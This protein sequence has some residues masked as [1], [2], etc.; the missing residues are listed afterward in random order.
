MLADPGNVLLLD[1]PTN[2]LDIHSID[3]LA[4]A[5][6]EFEGTVI[7]VSHDERFI[8][9]FCTRIVEIRPGALR[10][11]PGTLGDYRASLEAGYLSDL[12]GGGKAASP[13]TRVDDDKQARIQRRQQ[14]KSIERA[15]DKIE[16]QIA[17][18]EGA[19]EEQQQI[20]DNPANAQDYTLLGSA[21]EAKQTLERQL[22]TL[23]G[24]WEQ[25]QAQLGALPA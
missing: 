4:D 23:M 15:I 24:E 25:Q 6:A 18:L 9:R 17:Q 5:L 22:E 19:L 13:Q 1:E 3:R 21:A 7:V 14:R 2:H 20:M 16:Q 10:D 12:S 8:S 11:F